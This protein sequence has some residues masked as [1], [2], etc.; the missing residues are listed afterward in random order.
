MGSTFREN[1][2]NELDYQ[3]MVVKELSAKTGIPVATLDCYLGAR[4]TMPSADA[5][6][7]I[8]RALK[9]SVEYLVTGEEADFKKSQKVLGS[10][11]WEIICRLGN[12]SVVQCRAILG[13]L[14]AFGE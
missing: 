12:L 6:V 1:L 10:E 8:A 13:L 14:K 7:K 3:G 4:A 11:A 5:A 9:V 2:R